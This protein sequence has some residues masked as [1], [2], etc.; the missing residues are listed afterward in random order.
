MRKIYSI[1]GKRELQELAG[2]KHYYNW[3]VLFLICLLTL[4][5]LGSALNIKEF[6]RQRMDSPFVQ[7]V[8][9]DVPHYCREASKEIA[10]NIENSLQTS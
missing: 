5:T 4:F 6:L 7:M 10:D 3:I 1:F 2:N 8:A 9:I